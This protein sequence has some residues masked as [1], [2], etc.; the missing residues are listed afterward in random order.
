MRS[1]IHSLKPLH[2]GKVR[3]IYDI[4]ADTMLLIATDRLSAF[5]V[6][7]PTPIPEK[8]AILTQISNW[9][10]SQT[11]GIIHNHLLPDQPGEIARR[12]I[13]DR[14]LQLRSKFVTHP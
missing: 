2:Q 8:G 10:F 9:W 6:V 7:L 5:D 1:S 14:D 3:D 12:G 13:T 4:D 11:A